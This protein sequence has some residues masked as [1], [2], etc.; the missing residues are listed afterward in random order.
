[1]SLQGKAEHKSDRAPVAIRQVQNFGVGDSTHRDR[2][3]SDDRAITYQVKWDLDA[4]L[5]T[6]GA[7]TFTGAAL[8]D[9]D[10]ANQA[11]GDKI[12]QLDCA[13]GLYIKQCV[14]AFV[15][16]PL[17]TPQSHYIH[18]L[19]WM[20]DYVVSDE[21]LQNTKDLSSERQLNIWRC[22]RQAGVEGEV[23]DRV[24]PK[25][26]TC[27]RGELEPLSLLLEGGLLYRLYADDFS[28]QCYSHL[29]Q[30]LQLLRFKNPQMKILEIGA[31]TGGATLPILRSLTSDSEADFLQYDFTDVSP[32]FFGAARNLLSEW[33]SKVTYKALDIERDAV[34]QG[35][36]EAS[37]DLVIA[38]N[39]LHA[40]H[41]MDDTLS[42]VRRLLRPGGKLAL[43]ELTRLRPVWAIWAGLL[44]GWW[45]GKCPRQVSGTQSVTED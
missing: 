10:K 45:N 12:G 13:A 15:A 24:G 42:N 5:L 23:V 40:T 6:E 7:V 1:M 14:D 30:Y 19:H 27:M 35:F 22:I 33:S 9:T 25:L 29:T 32:G 21:F 44:P 39:V 3:S 2:V 8:Q 26:E 20:R 31:G 18:L 28:T 17:E 36:T 4:G 11:A 16:K 34:A 38:S 43:I 41:K 37:Y